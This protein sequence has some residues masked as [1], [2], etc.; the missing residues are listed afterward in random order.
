MSHILFG[1]IIALAFIGCAAPTVIQVTPEKDPVCGFVKAD[2]H[3]CVLVEGAKMHVRCIDVE[4][5]TEPD[6]ETPRDQ[7]PARDS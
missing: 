1:L 6:A 7:N 5:K 2:T 4:V 3:C